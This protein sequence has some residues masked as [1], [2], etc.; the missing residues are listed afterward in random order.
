VAIENGKKTLVLVEAEVRNMCVLLIEITNGVLTMF[1]L[2][3][4][5]S[6]AK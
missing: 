3:P 5:I 2:H 6:A 4:C 1:S